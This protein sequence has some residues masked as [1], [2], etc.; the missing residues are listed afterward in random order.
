MILPKK[1]IQTV[2]PAGESVSPIID[3]VRVR[4]ATTHPDER[5]SVTEV[6]NPLWGFT[7]EPLVY[8]YEFTIRPGCAKGW[9]MHK[10]QTDRVFLQ[11]GALRVVLYDDRAD[12]PTYQ[13]LNQFTL[14]EQNRG[15]ICYPPGVYHAL[16]NVGTTDTICIN[17][18][19]R[20]YNHEN[21]D[22][23]RLPLNNDT[24]PFRF[25]GITGW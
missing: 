20:A 14:T 23:Y 2:T 25:E 9:I 17:M 18:P 6:F 21:P 22:K 15:L 24:I 8:V 19:T 10:L 1:D 11:R 7:N 4:Y 3:G 16:Q 12:S 5:G 13:M